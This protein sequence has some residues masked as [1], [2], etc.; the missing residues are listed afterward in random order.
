[1]DLPAW[2]EATNARTRGA[3]DAL[4]GRRALVE[5]YTELFAAGTAG[6]PSIRGGRVFS[7]DRWGDHE[8]AVLVVRD[9]H[10]DG[11]PAAR[12]LLDPHAL[13]GDA[14]AALDWYAPS[15]DGSRV[16]FG[17]STGGDERSTLGIVEVATGERL[18]D[19]IPHTRA[20]SVA[21]TPDGTAFAYTR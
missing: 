5:R 10:G 3:L 2:V 7:V 20:A 9:L 14:T 12:T 18:T 19:T 15:P 4:P 16:A 1:P 13:T 6:A 17:I 21:W 11:P 8:Q